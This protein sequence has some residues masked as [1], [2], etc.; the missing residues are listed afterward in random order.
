MLLKVAAKEEFGLDVPVWKQGK[1]KFKPEEIID[2]RKAVRRMY[3]ET[4]GRGEPK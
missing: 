2:A 1:H 3:E 4:Q